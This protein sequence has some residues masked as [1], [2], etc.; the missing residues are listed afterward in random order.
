MLQERQQ[1][2]V[3]RGMTRHVVLALDL[4]ELASVQSNDRA[5]RKMLL[6]NAAKHFVRD[7]F[8]QNPLS[9]LSL[10]VT[11]AG[12]AEKLTEMSGL[13]SAFGASRTVHHADRRD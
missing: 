6:V 13:Y 9:H 5:T 11:H 1:G 8:D 3:R 4:S 2:K 10:I 7:F 12:I